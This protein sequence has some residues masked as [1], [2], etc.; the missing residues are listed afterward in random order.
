MKQTTLKRDVDMFLGKSLKIHRILAILVTNYAWFFTVQQN[1]GRSK[2]VIDQAVPVSAAPYFAAPV[3]KTCLS[4]NYLQK[5]P[6]G[7][8]VISIYLVD[9]TAPTKSSKSSF[10]MGND[11]STIL[12]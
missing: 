12:L 7:N 8:K 1:R 4:Q 3:S 11:R 5:C 10:L 2:S 9:Q 6:N